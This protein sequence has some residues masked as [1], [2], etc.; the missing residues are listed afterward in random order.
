[1]RSRKTRDERFHRERRWRKE[2][3]SKLV[4]KAAARPGA[5]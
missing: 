2:D 4:R 5:I 3:F 1:V